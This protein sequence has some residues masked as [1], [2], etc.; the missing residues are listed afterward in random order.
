MRALN[1]RATD[2]VQE[3]RITI[4]KRVIIS[5]MNGTQLER[6]R[7]ERARLNGV[8][9]DAVRLGLFEVAV[10]PEWFAPYRDA[11][12]VAHEIA[13]SRGSGRRDAV[14]LELAPPEFA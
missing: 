4:R 3:L 8:S 13:A 5:R 14:P 6:V 1:T 12:Q 7:R 2:D 9:A 11:R 10:L